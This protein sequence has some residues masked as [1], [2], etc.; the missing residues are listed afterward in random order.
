MF[1]ILEESCT[2]TRFIN[3]NHS[4]ISLDRSSQGECGGWD[5]CHTREREENCPRFWWGSLKKRDH[6]EDRGAGE[7]KGSEWIW[8]RLAGGCG[9]D[10]VG[11]G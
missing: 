7:R 3:C 5:M 10:P 2:M 8:G 9:V 11:S 6:N 4:Q 1:R